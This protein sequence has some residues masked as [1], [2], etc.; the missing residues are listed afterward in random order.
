VKYRAVF[1]PAHLPVGGDANQ[2]VVSAVF[3]LP[4]RVV[5][6][7]QAVSRVYPTADVLPEN[8]LKFYL[9][10]TGPMRGGEVYDHIHLINAKGQ[11]VELPFLEIGEELWDTTMTRLTLF[12]DPGRIKRGVTP[13]EE[14]G[15][16]L[17]EGKE[18][19]LVIDRDWQD[20]EGNPLK[21]EFRRKFKVGPPQR[22]ALDPKKWKI[23]SPSTGGQAALT[24][25]FPVPVDHA[26]ALR[27]IQVIDEAG[28]LVAGQTATQ[29]AERQWTF[30]PERPWRAG[31]YQIIVQST[32]EDVAGN[33]IGKPFEVDLFEGVERRITNTATKLP[34]E[35][36]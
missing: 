17:E 34:F 3:Q 30:T 31:K 26:L 1:R 24:M 14:I 25:A 21:Q 12:I 5:K 10:F 35:V 23:K 9:H 32:F 15:P 6:P 33:N 19:T 29:D 22:E 16:S 28:Q 13:L 18:F 8:L 27:V 7:V 11:E 20:A 2:R 36:R 4:A